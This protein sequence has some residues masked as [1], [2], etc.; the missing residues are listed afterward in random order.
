[1]PVAPVAGAAPAPFVPA[2]IP[3]HGI[4]IGVNLELRVRQ[5]R[6]L[7][8]HIHCI[9]RDFIPAQATLAR[10]ERVWALKERIDRTKEDNKDLSKVEVLLKV[11]NIRKTVE[12]IDE[13]LGQRLGAYGAPLSYLVQDQVVPEDPDLGF[14]VPDAFSEMI[15]Q[16]RHNGDQ[17]EEDNMTL[18]AIVRQV[19]H[20]GP[21]WNWVKPFAST[22]NGRSAYFALKQHYLGKSFQKRN[23]AHA[24]RILTTV[25]YDGKSRNFTFESFCEKLNLAFLDLEEAGEVVTE[26]RK[27]R[28]LLENI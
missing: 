2:M 9:Q 1:M 3:N 22:K 8:F 4:L 11:E 15:R 26:E 5:L 17:F 13:N 23:V 10:L 18:W 28:I 7:L 14:G 19:T 16:T 6:Y 25:F 27:V 24:E 12:D 21:A 20:G